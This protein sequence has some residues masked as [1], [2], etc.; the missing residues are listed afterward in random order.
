[1]SVTIVRPTDGHKVEKR[2]KKKRVRFKEDVMPNRYSSIG[3]DDIDSNKVNIPGNPV[4]CWDDQTTRVKVR[5]ISN[6]IVQD[7]IEGTPIEWKMVPRSLSLQMRRLTSL[8]TDQILNHR[9]VIKLSPMVK[10]L[11]GWEKLKWKLHSESLFLNDKY[12]Q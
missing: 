4:E 11:Y 6:M 5:G 3:K 2:K 7:Q 12:G 8:L 9:T 10:N 1:M